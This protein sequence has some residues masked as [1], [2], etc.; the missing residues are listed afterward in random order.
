MFLVFFM[1]VCSLCVCFVF[2][3]GTAGKKGARGL[4]GAPGVEVRITISPS[5]VWRREKLKLRV[6][7]TVISCVVMMQLGIGKLLNQNSH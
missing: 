1:Y 2:F 6:F 5:N 7:F 3:Q 4:S